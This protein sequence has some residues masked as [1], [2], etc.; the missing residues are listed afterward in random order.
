MATH[1]LKLL[2]CGTVRFLKFAWPFFNIIH[3]RVKYLKIYFNVKIELS[4]LLILVM[5]RKLIR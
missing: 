1:T 3:E 5:K 4:L 2:R